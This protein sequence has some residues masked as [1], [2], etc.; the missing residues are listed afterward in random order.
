MKL[1]TLVVTVAVLAAASVAVFFLQR[2]AP[3]ASADPHVGQPLVTDATL[4]ETARFVL[5]DQGKTVTLAR[6][7]DGTW[8]VPA[9]YDLPVDF[10][11]LS[12]LIDDLAAAKIQRAVTRNPER[13]ARLEFK[14]TKLQ[15]FDAAGKSLWSV[16]LGK[17]ADSGGRFLRFDDQPAAYLA[18]FSAWLDAEPKNW[19]DS[20]LLK[21][22]AD[23]I[24]KV[25]I[26][27]ADDAPVVV[28]REKKEAPWTAAKTP[29][30]Q[31]VNPAKITSLLSSLDTLRFTDTTA[32]DD[33][34]AVAARA[35][36]RT[37]ALTTFAGETVTVA[38]GREPE[39]K[40]LK[41]PSADAKSGPAALGT[42]ADLEKKESPEK[43]GSP[44]AP[45]QPPLPEFETIPA[46][47]VFAFIKNSDRAAPIN[48][49]MAKR[50]FQ[51]SDYTFTSL[52]QKPADLFEPAPKPEAAK[53]AE[54]P[55]NT[56][57]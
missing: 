45:A 20:S 40:K 34:K 54:K 36:E 12:R 31:Q 9:Y 1:R 33:A 23:D 15:L 21:L 24:A 30:G 3:P 48:A 18:S 2:P 35:H 29:D 52:P 47:P 26:G 22:K 25:E 53:P 38:L 14:D 39:Q 13:I 19:A 6:Q 32:P 28:S 56:K 57:G 44:S 46:G 4:Q 51:I 10:S 50:A 17:N 5:S 7:A 49:L 11:K 37:L 42:T 55:D 27:F 16:T 8:R 43:S 41:P